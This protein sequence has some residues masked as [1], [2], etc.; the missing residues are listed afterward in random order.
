MSDTAELAVTTETA[1]GFMVISKM[2]RTGSVKPPYSYQYD[3]DCYLSLE[4]AEEYFT[5]MERGEYRGWHPVAIIPTKA[6][7]P[8]G[9]K[10]VL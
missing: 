6:G 10:K 8:L 4:E 5:A 2:L 1:D 9:A 7:I 3:A